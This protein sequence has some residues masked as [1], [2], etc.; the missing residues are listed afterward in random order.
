MQNIL[1]IRS[2]VFLLLALFM[3][4][5]FLNFIFL[6]Q[7]DSVEQILKNIIYSGISIVVIVILYGYFIINQ[8]IRQFRE[9]SIKDNNAK[10]D[11]EE[12]LVHETVLNNKIDSMLQQ[13]SIS[14]NMG[15]VSSSIFNQWRERLNII[16]VSMS[17]I[18]LKQDFDIDITKDEL[19]KLSDNVLKTTHEMADIISN[20]GLLINLTERHH[21]MIS[22][23]IHDVLNIMN[24]LF[25]VPSIDIQIKI[26]EDA[27]FFGIKALLSHVILN[28]LQNS[29]DEFNSG[30]INKK[31]IQIRQ[32]KENDNIIIKIKDNAGGVNDDILGKIFEQFFTTRNDFNKVGIGLYMCYRILRKDF[33]G[34]IFCENELDEYGLGAC[35]TVKIPIRHNS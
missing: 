2:I 25:R 6:Y 29:I 23:S 5:L 27:E 28:I 13:Q 7:L 11:L 4:V 16:T 31:I 24:D 10:L 32:Y 3:T 22:H 9:V 8:N 19:Y 30:Q 15:N 1:K 18:Q 34:Y 21:F 26:Y 35:L 33:N 20:F 12:K 14:S 17:S